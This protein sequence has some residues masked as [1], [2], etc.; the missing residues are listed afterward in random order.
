[1]NVARLNLAHGNH[2]YHQGVMERIRKLNREKGFSVAVMVSSRAGPGWAAVHST[3]AGLLPRLVDRAAAASRQRP[4]RLGPLFGARVRA[5][6][7]CFHGMLDPKHAANAASLLPW[8]CDNCA[9]ALRPNALQMDTEG[10][11]V[12]INDL[13]AP[14][15]AD[16]AAEFSFSV[17]DPASCG[18]NCFSV[19]CT[20][21]G[22][23]WGRAWR[24]G[25]QHFGRMLLPPDVQR[26]VQGLG[27]R[28]AGDAACAMP[29]LGVRAHA[30]LPAATCP[31]SC[32]YDG[33]IED[34][35]PGDLLV[36]FLHPTRLCLLPLFFSTATFHL[37]AP[38]GS[39]PTLATSVHRWWM[40]AWCRWRC[41][42]KRGRTSLPAWWTL[43]GGR[44]GRI[45]GG[46]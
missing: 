13:P 24:S 27:S 31:C 29:R 10:S 36:G 35:Q 20:G 19:R 5:L 23:G 7:V 32:S 34:A 9:L 44:A 39:I 1:M 28:G 6:P 11:E 14:V 3:A 46:G 30:C 45:G 16:K 43:V 26:V 8:R 40:A 12:H 2:A 25:R 42:Q 37:L 18:P 17:R 38:C 4:R 21:Q 41:C 22:R 33:F 15:K